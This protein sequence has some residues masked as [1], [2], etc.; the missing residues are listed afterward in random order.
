MTEQFLLLGTIILVGFF[1]S[2]FFKKT[3]IPDVLILLLFGVILGPVTNIVA[4]GY[5]AGMASFVGTLALILVLFDGGLNLNISEVVKGVPE[6]IL[7]AL[8]SFIISSVLVGSALHFLAGWN[9]LHALLMG[10]VVGGTSSPIVMSIVEKLRAGGKAKT[11]LSLESVITD[12]L[13]I[14]TAVVLVELIILKSFNASAIAQDLTSA[15]TTAA[16]VGFLF[17]VFWVGILRKFYGKPFGYVV[18][19]AAIFIMYAFVESIGGSGAVSVLCFSLVLGN[20]HEI[21]Q[22]LRIQGGSEIDE[23]IR[24]VQRE[25]SFF[26]KTFFFVYLGFLFNMNALQLAPLSLALIILAAIYIGRTIAV[27][28]LV[29]KEKH[30]E[31]DSALMLS[32]APRGLAAAVLAFLPLNSGIKIDYFS[33]IAFLIILFTSIVATAG[34]FMFG[35]GVAEETATTG[36]SDAT[37]RQNKPRVV[38]KR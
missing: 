22:Y 18:T 16:V 31:K 14:I 8:S 9:F 11:V 5:F 2:L 4:P 36:K 29:A 3:R 37:S 23:N 1:G 17:G 7:F 20:S 21:F 19:L 25:I 34:A 28:I 35:G 12:V 13:C 26:V 27:R 33:D 6:A 24:I 10:V 38:S 32:L 30:F 15:F